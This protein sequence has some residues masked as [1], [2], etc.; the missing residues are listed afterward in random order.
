MPY[1]TLEKRREWARANSDRV[2]QYRMKWTQSDKGKAYIKK[3]KEHAAKQKEL[4]GSTM[5]TSEEIK[6][7]RRYM[8]KARRERKRSKA[9]DI[10]GGCCVVCGIDDKDVLHFDHIE[11]LKRKTNGIKK[12]RE[13]YYYVLSINEPS[14]VYQ[15]L[16][17]NCHTKKTRENNEWS[18]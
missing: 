1:D 8:D 13:N 12:Q 6:Q 10:L 14:E 4:K 11:P 17:A 9:I 18:V 3:Q 7:R 15:L 2:K 5:P 16:C